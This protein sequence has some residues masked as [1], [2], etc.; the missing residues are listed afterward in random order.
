MNLFEAG[1]LD[2]M[3]NSEYEKMFGAQP[4]KEINIDKEKTE[5]LSQQQSEDGGD[6]LR[7]QMKTQELSR[8]EPISLRMV[9]RSLF[10]I[11]FWSYS[12]SLGVIF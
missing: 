1:I 9:K 6:I 11:A 8:L 4:Q 2:K 12:S 5:I 3:T 10:C 7:I